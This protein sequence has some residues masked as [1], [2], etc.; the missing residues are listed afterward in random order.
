MLVVVN[1]TQ[2]FACKTQNAFASESLVSHGVDVG[3]VEGL[4][5]WAVPVCACA[6]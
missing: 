5:D 6:M 4:R 2:R 1:E 3:R